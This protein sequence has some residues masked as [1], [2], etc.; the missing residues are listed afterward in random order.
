MGAEMIM[1]DNREPQEERN[2]RDGVHTLVST[3][4]K[5]A[6]TMVTSFTSL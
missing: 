5:E 1:P 3:S 6:N 4:L 2:C